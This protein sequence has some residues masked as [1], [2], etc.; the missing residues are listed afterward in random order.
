MLHLGDGVLPFVKEHGAT[1]TVGHDEIGLVGLHRLEFLLGVGNRVAAV[2]LHKI[3]AEAETAAVTA[4]RVIYHLATPSLDHTSQHV[5]KFRIADA[6]FREYLG[7]VATDVLY[8]AQRLARKTVNQL[9]LHLLLQL[10]TE[11]EDQIRRMHNVLGKLERPTSSF[12]EILAGFLQDFGLLLPFLHQFGHHTERGDTRGNIVLVST[13]GHQ[14]EKPRHDGHGRFKRHHI[15]VVTNSRT[16][17]LVGGVINV[18]PQIIAHDVQE[19]RLRAREEGLPDAT[20]FIEEVIVGNFFLIF[21][22]KTFFHYN[23]YRLWVMG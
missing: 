10:E 7:V 5:G 11:L 12:F 13:F 3:L 16:S 15:G 17:M 23:G 19:G 18:L 14:R 21:V 20:S 9:V 4:F 1:G 2:F 6:V 22:P 8:P